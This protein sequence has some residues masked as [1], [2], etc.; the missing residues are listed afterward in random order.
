M[1]SLTTGLWVI[2]KYDNEDFPGELNCVEGTDAEVNVMHRRWPKPEDKVF[3][4][5]A[6]N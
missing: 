1:Q 5:R 2:V 4:F 3:Y 6:C